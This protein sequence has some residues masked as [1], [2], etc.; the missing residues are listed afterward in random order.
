MLKFARLLIILHFFRAYAEYISP[1][2]GYGALQGYVLLH[3]NLIKKNRNTH[4]HKHR[5]DYCDTE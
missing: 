4:T 1:N 2:I 5:I 3:T